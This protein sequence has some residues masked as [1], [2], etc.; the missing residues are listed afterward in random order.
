MPVDFIYAGGGRLDASSLGIV[1]HRVIATLLADGIRKPTREEIVAIA[2]EELVGLRGPKRR[3]ALRGVVGL[4]MG[5]FRE[6]APGPDTR[7]IGTELPVPGARLDILFEEPGGAI[8]SDEIKT[9]R[10]QPRDMDRL[11]SQ[12]VNNVRGANEVFGAAFIGARASILSCPERSYMLTS[13][14]DVVGLTPNWKEV[15]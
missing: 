1:V 13:V 14:G 12:M 6:F 5:Y 15:A 7:V 3:S 11:F 10:M 2:H 8:W 4:V 9:G